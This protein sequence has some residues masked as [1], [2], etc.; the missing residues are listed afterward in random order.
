M[1]G[2]S[3]QSD[4]ESWPLT[5]TDCQDQQDQLI[6]CMKK[7]QPPFFCSNSFQSKK[8][9]K[10]NF[11]HVFVHDL[12]NEKMEKKLIWINPFPFTLW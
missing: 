10:N 9:G 11:E 6:E 3:N 2:T 8:M 4:P 1:V 12:S 5:A 7:S